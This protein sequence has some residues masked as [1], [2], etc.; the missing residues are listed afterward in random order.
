MNMN[1]SN[2]ARIHADVYHAAVTNILIGL[3][4]YA[5][6]ALRLTAIEGQKYMGFFSI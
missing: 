3:K 5:D 1:G 2:H 4:S 6:V